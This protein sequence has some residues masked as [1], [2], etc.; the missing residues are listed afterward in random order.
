[1]GL[2]ILIAEPSEIL[3]WGLRAL[4]TT[5]PLV[6][7]I[8]EAV[9]RED[10]QRHL[11][12]TPLHLVLAHQSLAADIKILPRDR[13]V[14]LATELDMKKLLVAHERGA[15][16]YIL[17]NTLLKDGS[18]ELL[19]FLLR[20]AEKEGEKVFFLDPIVTPY[21][22]D[23]LGD[24]DL[25]PVDLELLTPR[26]REICYLL[27]DGYK[28]IEIAEQFCISYATVRTHIAHILR[29]LNVRRHQLM[30]LSLPARK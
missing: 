10:L 29:K 21:I 27:H 24:N 30:R 23:C 1:M 4:F 20:M 18:E 6:D 22:L 3:R 9:T 13:F 12:F 5:H 7:H 16:G 19:R 8:Y 25:Q 28:D 11:K 26:E 15:C 14:L 17:E 2:N